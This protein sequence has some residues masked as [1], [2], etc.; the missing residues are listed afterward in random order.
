M[1]GSNWKGKWLR[2]RKKDQK[3][4]VLHTYKYEC[5]KG[6]IRIEKQKLIELELICPACQK[7]GIDSKFRFVGVHTLTKQQSKLSR[8][9][10]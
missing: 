4:P 5:N 1:K 9:S 8:F 7:E 10:K 3:N 6:H 2:Q